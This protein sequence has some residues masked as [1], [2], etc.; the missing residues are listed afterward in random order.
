MPATV[1][2]QTTTGNIR[3]ATNIMDS[4]NSKKATAGMPVNAVD[5][6]KDRKVGNSMAL[7]ISNSRNGS[8]SRGSCNFRDASKSRDVTKSMKASNWMDAGN[9]RKVKKTWTPAKEET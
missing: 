3:D 5:H 4:C 8:N 6:S 2:H 9:S 1:E 7:V